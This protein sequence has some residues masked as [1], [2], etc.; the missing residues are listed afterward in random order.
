M[1]VFG[2]EE[3]SDIVDFRRPPHGGPFYKFPPI[4]GA[5]GRAPLL[6][7]GIN[8]R[9][10]DTNR[11][12]HEW[13]MRSSENFERLAAKNRDEKDET[14]IA[15]AGPEPHYHCHAIVVEGVFGNGTLFES[16]AAVTELFLCASKSAPMTYDRL[17]SEKSPCADRYLSKVMELVQPE[18]IIS[19]GGT[20]KGHLSQFFTKP[21]N[22]PVVFMKHPAG[23]YRMSQSE[24]VLELQ[25]TI[26]AIKEVCKSSSEAVA[27]RS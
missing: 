20:V 17:K 3:C 9:R 26:N 14:Y 6:F 10:T 8:P 19:V 13:L 24:K 16:K 18:V 22:V 1:K 21:I 23:L 4:I 27:R 11:D 12:L 7:I 2:C 5:Q 25:P 15:P